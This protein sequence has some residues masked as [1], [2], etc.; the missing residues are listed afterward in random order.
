[1]ATQSQTVP[2]PNARPVAVTGTTAAAVAVTL[3]FVLVVLAFQ[4]IGAPW[5]IYGSTDATYTASGVDLMAGEHT[6]YLDQPGMPLQDLMAIT[7]E[8]RYVAHKLT[9]EHETPHT[10]AAERLLHLDDSRIFFRG[11]AILF[12]VSGA[13]LAFV[14]LRGLLG[15]AWWGAAGGLLFIA[16]PG[17]P[18]MSIQF[19]PDVLLAGLVLATGWLIIRAAE[20]RDA[21]LYTLAAFLVGLTATVEVHAAGL[22]VP[23]ALA[24]LSRPPRAGRGFA[25]AKD[26]MRRYRI[27]LLAF[28]TLWI[29]FCVT[30]DR[31]RVPLRTSHHNATVMTAIG[32]VAVAYAVLVAIGG[33]VPAMQKGPLRPI[34][35]LLAAAFAAGVLL[36][37]TLV[38]NDLPNMIVDMGRALGH[39]GVDRAAPG[40]S[41]NWSELVHA[42][43]LLALFLLVLASVAAGIGL[44]ARER[45]PVLWFSGA[46]TMFLMATAH[47]GPAVNFAPA[48]VLSIAPVLWLARRLPRA[49]APLA[50]GA[51][52]AAC[53]VPTL[54]D[55][56]K[57]ADAAPAQEREAAAMT[58]RAD[59]LLTR[60][61][62]VAL[63]EDFAPLPDV[64]WQDFVQQ[65]VPWTPTYPYRFLPDSPAGVNTSAHLHLAPAFYIGKLAAGIQT[66]QSVPIQFGAYEMKPLAAGGLAQLGLGATQLLSGPAIDRPLEHPDARLDPKTGYYLDPSGHYWDL[67]GNPIANPPRS[68]G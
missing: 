30:F 7:T 58:S 68:S 46:A 4:P 2:Q 48:F 59:Q 29:L 44:V 40:T 47:P 64:R 11:Y 20:E 23:L 35:F 41:A 25:Q 16:A 52:V 3:V 34:G 56:A 43:V 39:G 21:W 49:A 67:W 19:A 42:P 10:Y 61:G 38:V 24:L 53:L 14:A 36:P 33:R 17:L 51:V 8:T 5:W 63:T 12:F 26:W 31:T 54:A 50:G 55:I 18:G 65:I 6:Q 66:R 62:T 57:P 1:M 9:S 60:P 15:G 13:L 28:F 32:L 45:Q 22:L 27:P 37:G